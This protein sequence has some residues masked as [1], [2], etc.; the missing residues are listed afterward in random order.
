MAR[1]PALASVVAALLL[2]PAAAIAQD[3]GTGGLGVPEAPPTGGAD[4]RT[5]LPTGGSETPPPPAVPAPAQAPEADPPSRAAPQKPTKRA[6]DDKGDVEVE[7]PVPKEER[8]EAPAASEPSRPLGLASTGFAAALLGF[9]GLVF[10]VAGVSLRR[11]SRAV[12]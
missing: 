6:Q 12:L 3:S 7:V 9:L 5:P 1:S 4:T 10:G 2:P 11:A 8:E